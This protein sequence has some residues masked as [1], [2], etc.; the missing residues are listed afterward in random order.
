MSRIIAIDYGRKRTGIAVTDSLQ[1][2]AAPLKVLPT[3]TVLPFLKEYFQKECVE[4]V[5]VGWPLELNGIKGESTRLVDQFIRF[6]KRHFP[7]V[8]VIRYDERFTSRMAEKSLVQAGVKKKQRQN[9]QVD[10]ISAAFILQSFM[11]EKVWRSRCREV[12]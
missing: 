9:I 7:H 11:E 10:A 6:I 12:V 4:M 3:Y 1:L 2:I 8:P 5:V